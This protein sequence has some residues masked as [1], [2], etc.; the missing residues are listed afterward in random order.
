[1]CRREG[2]NVRSIAEDKDSEIVYSGSRGDQ[3]VRRIRQAVRRG[4]YPEVRCGGGGGA[5]IPPSPTNR[6]TADH[7]GCRTQR[8]RIR[9]QAFSGLRSL[10]VACNKRTGYGGV[11]RIA[12]ADCQG[13][14]VSKRG[15]RA[16][17]VSETVDLCRR[18]ARVGI[19]PVWRVQIG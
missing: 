10:I 3:E 13:N 14:D 6:E 19:P 1:V 11:K 7:R 17:V 8:R 12:L 5:G 16:G 18:P 15:R 4:N 2:T 9:E